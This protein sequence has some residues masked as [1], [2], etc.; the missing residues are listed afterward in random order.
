M[1]EYRLSVRARAQ[2]IDIY[3]FTS[4]T[5]GPYQAEA[6]HAG[7]ERTFSLL[8]DFPRIGQSVD[9]L[10][11]GH[12]RFRFQSHNVFYTEENGHVLIR[13]VYHHAQDIRPKL[14][15]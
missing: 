15:D 6:Y 9:E 1:A 7:L 10:A 3:E 8:A 14:F 5:F 11:P 12:R 13:A 4:R 2:L